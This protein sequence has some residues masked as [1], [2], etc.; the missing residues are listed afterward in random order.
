MFSFMTQLS[1][2]PASRDSVAI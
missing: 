2:I 1:Q